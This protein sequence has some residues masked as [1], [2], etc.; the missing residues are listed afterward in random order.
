MMGKAS[1]EMWRGRTRLVFFK[2][3]F[4]SSREGQLILQAFQMGR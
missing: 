4:F 2:I 3:Q 1:A